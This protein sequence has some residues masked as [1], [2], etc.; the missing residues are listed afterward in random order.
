MQVQRGYLSKGLMWS[1][2]NGQIVFPSMFAPPLLGFDSLMQN[3]V[4]A[5]YKKFRR[6]QRAHGVRTAAWHTWCDASI[7]F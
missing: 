7:P 4:A 5:D 1:Y 2:F 3:G 6:T